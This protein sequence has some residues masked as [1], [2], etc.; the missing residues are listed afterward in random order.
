SPNRV[1]TPH[2]SASAKTSVSN[3]LFPMPGGPSMTSTQPR[4]CATAVTSAPISFSSSARPRIGGVTRR[5][6]PPSNR[7]VE[8]PIGCAVYRLPDCHCSAR[9]CRPAHVIY[10]ICCRS[11]GAAHELRQLGAGGDAELGEGVV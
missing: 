8:G 1:R 9:H 6:P 10:P 11:V 3:R 4:P 2:L 7:P 5:R